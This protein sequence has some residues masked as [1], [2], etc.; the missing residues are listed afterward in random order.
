MGPP[1]GARPDVMAS[2]VDKKCRGCIRMEQEQ[3]TSLQ[4]N[5]RLLDPARQCAV[6]W[7]Q[8]RRDARVYL[9]SMQLRT[10]LKCRPERRS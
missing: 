3:T 2:I 1:T 8:I 5:R 6:L 10:E 9:Y 7:C 4:T